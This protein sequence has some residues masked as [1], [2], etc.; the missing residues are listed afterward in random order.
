MCATLIC[1]VGINRCL[2]KM[3]VQCWARCRSWNPIDSGLRCDIQKYVL[4][5]L[6]FFYRKKIEKVDTIIISVW[7]SFLQ[8]QNRSQCHTKLILMSKA[9]LAI[10]SFKF[11]RQWR[12]SINEDLHIK[13]HTIYK[14]DILPR[15]YFT[16]Q[17]NPHEKIWQSRRSGRAED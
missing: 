12:A 3:V 2:Y 17:D 13:T 9:G 5:R 4:Q 7:Q 6:A 14:K 10:R 15:I 8:K 11:V 1:S 16:K